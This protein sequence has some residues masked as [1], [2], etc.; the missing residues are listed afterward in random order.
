MIH[1]PIPPHRQAAYAGLGYAA[2]AFAIAKTMADEVLSLPIG[3]HLASGQAEE[4][5]TAFKAPQNV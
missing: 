3:P 2:N 1:Y 4:V 5:I